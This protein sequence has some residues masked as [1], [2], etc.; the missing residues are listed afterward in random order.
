MNPI[1]LSIGT[2]VIAELTYR[3][4]FIDYSLEKEDGSLDVFNAK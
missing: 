1:N 3:L 4:K 2:G